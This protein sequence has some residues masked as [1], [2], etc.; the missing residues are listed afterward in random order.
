MTFGVANVTHWRYSFVL[1]NTEEPRLTGTVCIKLPFYPFW[2]KALWHLMPFL[3]HLM[4]L[5]IWLVHPLLCHTKRLIT[6]IWPYHRLFTLL[7]FHHTY[8]LLKVKKLIPSLFFHFLQ[9]VM[10]RG[11]SL[12]HHFVYKMN[13]VK[14]VIW[15]NWWTWWQAK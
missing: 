9:K 12:C 2:R 7:A 8:P 15:K 11:T 13:K 3:W 1:Q 10:R 14:T 6:P 5:R 4:P